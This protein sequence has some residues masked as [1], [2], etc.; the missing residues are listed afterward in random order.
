MR[1]RPVDRFDT[2]LAAGDLGQVCGAGAVFGQAGDGVHDLLGQQGAGGVVAVAADPDSPGDVREVDAD[3]IGDPQGSSDD[4][5]VAVVDLEVVRLARA[6][7][8]DG[9]V[10]GALQ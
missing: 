6:A 4:P 1:C 10:G 3:S 8:L 5:A 2:P 9:V 7:G